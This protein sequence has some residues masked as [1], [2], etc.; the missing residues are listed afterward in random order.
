MNGYILRSY[1]RHFFRSRYWRG[2][3]VHSPFVFEF[4]REIVN[5]R[6]S[7]YHFDIVED[8][9]SR[10]I[11]NHR[12][13]FFEEM[14]SGK[15]GITQKK[16]SQLAKNSAVSRKYGRLLSRIVAFVK[17]RIMLEI[18]TSL[19]VGSLYIAMAAKSSEF[20]TLEG[21]PECA[22]IASKAL[23]ANGCKNAKVVVGNFDNTLASVLDGVDTLD[24][25]WFDGNHSY[26]PTINYFNQCLTKVGNDSVFVFDDIHCSKEM[27]DAWA[28]IVAHPAVSVSVEMYRIGVVFFRK[29]CRKQ[30]FRLRW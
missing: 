7:F 6:H 21:N 3:G 24:F 17:P 12:T 20:V 23:A 13:I 10:L 18:G 4:V 1:L 2:H 8:Y 14:G 9:R 28:Y 16:I 19:G 22:S 26:S 5:C 27:S 25:V 29:E 15:P 30:N 11:S